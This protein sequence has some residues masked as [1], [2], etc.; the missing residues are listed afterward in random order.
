M[1]FQ[2]ELLK[3]DPQTKARAGVFHTQ[4]G[5]VKTPIFMP[6]GT[7]A[8][9]KTL[10]SR[11]LQ[12]LGAQIILGNTYHL[13][14]RPGAQVFD[15][16]GGIHSLIN[17]KRPVLTDSGGYQLF[18][19]P[20]RRKITEEG[21][22]FH[23][24]TDGRYHMLSPETSIAMQESINSDIMMVLDECV[25]STVD[26]R[27]ARRAMELTHRWALRSLNARKKTQ[28]ALFA[29]VQGA[30]DRELRR[31]SAHFLT[32]H[33]FDGFAVG[34]LAVGESK[35][36]REDTTEFVTDMLPKD[37]PRYLMGVGT[38]IDLLEGIRRGID[39][40]DC[41]LP[42]KYAQQGIAFTSR[43]KLGTFRKKYQFKDEPLDPHCDCFCCKN[44]SLAYIHHLTKCLEPVGWRL[45]V[46]HNL[47]HYLKLMDDA[48]SSILENQ[49]EQFYRTTL[50]AIGIS[51]TGTSN[52]Y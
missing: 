14:L 50:D 21:A 4:H 29:I 10:C 23:S 12:D 48:R 34:G 15:H 5:S 39:M 31:E 37:R 43:G 6:V 41:I 30:T 8:A 16:V 11:D 51:D 26:N 22:V 25:P 42:T 44:Y 47:A 52:L 49:F 38:P 17:W 32:Q 2:F 3:T 1:K 46:I 27:E 20:H 35:S 19:L 45:L 36:E 24:Y 13:M 18:C 28:N 7:F 9:V 33:P 40:F